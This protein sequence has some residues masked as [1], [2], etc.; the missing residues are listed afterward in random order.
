MTYDKAQLTEQFKAEVH[1]K[2]IGDIEDEFM[3]E[4]FH[5]LSLGWA[6]AKGL[7]FEDAFDFA[8]YIRYDTNLG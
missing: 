3:E 8:S 4:D 7:S 6:I 1:D 2:I 5:S